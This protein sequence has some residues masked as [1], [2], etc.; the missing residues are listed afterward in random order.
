MVVIFTLSR[1]NNHYRKRDGK[2]KKNGKIK[3]RVLGF[4]VL[5]D[6]PSPLAIILKIGLLS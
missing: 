2:Q 3:K 4:R 5:R 6:Y 1:L